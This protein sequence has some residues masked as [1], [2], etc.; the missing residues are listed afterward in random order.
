MDAVKDPAQLMR[1]KDGLALRVACTR[2]ALMNDEPSEP[3]DDS[4]SPALSHFEVASEF[5]VLSM[6]AKR[7]SSIKA[8]GGLV[9]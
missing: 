6:R 1:L 5:K 8:S 3:A 2:R 7:K 9:K 4:E